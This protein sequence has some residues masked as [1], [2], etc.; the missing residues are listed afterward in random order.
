MKN[1]CGHE[2]EWVWTMRKLNTP[3]SVSSYV[4]GTAF[5]GK[6]FDYP[7]HLS[8]TWYNHGDIYFDREEIT[9]IGAF[10]QYNIEQ[11]KTYPCRIAKRVFSLARR[12]DVRKIRGT[13]GVSLPKLIKLFQ[14]ER[15]DFLVMTGFMSYR[16]S[17]QMG[18]ILHEKLK[19]MLVGRLGRKGQMSRLAA[20]LEILSYP[21]YESIIVAEKKFILQQARMFSGASER[22][23]EEIIGGYLSRY[24]WIAYHWFVG[25][26]PSRD[27][28]S[29][30]L[31]TFASA[32]N[33]EL[34]TLIHE[35]ETAESKIRKVIMDLRLN[36][37]ERDLVRDY[38][39]WLFIRSCVKDSINKAGYKLLPI[40]YAIAE[41]VGIEPAS[42][43]YLTLQEIDSI[44]TIPRRD[45]E[46]HIEARRG[47]F[48]AGIIHN[49]FRFGSFNASRVETAIHDQG[50]VITGSVAYKGK[51]RGVARVLLSPK[52]QGSLQEGEI[53]VTSMTTPD[54]LLAME[55]AAAFVT[56][57]GGI[58]C[59][60]AIVAREMRK[61]CIIGTKMATQR[62]QSGDIIEVDAMSGKVI[63]IS[64]S[65]L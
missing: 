15:K 24:A 46:R 33:E 48:S 6:N 35:Q 41:R 54:F 29:G 37:A 8:A 52:E 64:A 42:I 56:D 5:G 51:V 30:R 44:K 12:I 22:R 16:G 4:P 63:V 17:V 25:T 36:S 27:E 3:L 55:R 18:D 13:D 10:L 2:I 62:L 59:H 58:T 21:M 38:R 9:V 23:Q 50:S 57:E 26:P 28:I 60:A 40:L 39:T 14:K 32:A 19:T 65:S 34:K 7:M 31:I 20:C 45:L 49:R 43:P 53:L 11:D 47:G 61:P 1:F